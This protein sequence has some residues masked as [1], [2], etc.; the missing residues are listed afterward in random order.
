VLLLQL[1]V[2]KL[3]L[4]KLKLLELELELKLHVLLLCQEL[5][6]RQELLLYRKHR[7]AG[8]V[9]LQ[10][11]RRGCTCGAHD[12]A[13]ENRDKQEPCKHERHP[14]AHV[15]CVVG[16]ALTCAC[17]LCQGLRGALL[18]GVTDDGFEGQPFFDF[19]FTSL[20]LRPRRQSAPV[21][22]VFQLQT[23]WS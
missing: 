3:E 13:D 18:H 14:Q 22:A 17:S 1:V 21:A 19:V 5:L 12:D 10:A 11:Q 8:P 4:V 16:F 7:C 20:C 15:T 2:V 9:A 6:L 23:R